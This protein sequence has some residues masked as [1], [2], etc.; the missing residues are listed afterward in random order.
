MFIR[1]FAV[2]A[3]V[4]GLWC[5]PA[6][7]Q[8]QSF[9]AF[10]AELWPD[11]QAKGITRATFDLAMQGVTP[12]PRVIAATK[13]PARIRQAGRRLCQ[14]RS[15][16]PAISHVGRRKAEEWSKTFDAVEKKFAVER[17]V[18]LALWGMETSYGTEKTNGTYSVR[19]PRSAMCAI[20]ILTF[21]TS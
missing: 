6:R 10:E 9:A 16:R 21:A 13:T 3:I 7:A 5:A 20:G 14:C 18:L 8:D 4:L 11:A 1:G 19:S 2:L 12:D 15:S 17:W